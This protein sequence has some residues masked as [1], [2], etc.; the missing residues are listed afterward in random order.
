MQQILR[1]DIPLG[2]SGED[3]GQNMDLDQLKDPE[4]AAK[5]FLKAYTMAKIVV[6]ID[7]HC[8]ENGFFV[9][10]GDSPTTYA[11]CSL[12]EVSAISLPKI[13]T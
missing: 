2:G 4:D 10:E 13:I 8:L 3:D 7:T 5:R 11:A 12:L 6:V 9:W 1:L